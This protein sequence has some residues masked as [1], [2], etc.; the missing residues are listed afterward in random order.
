MIIQT[1]IEIYNTELDD[2]GIESTM[3]VRF[4]VDTNEICAVREHIEKGETEPRLSKCVIYLKSGESFIVYL[5]YDYLVS[6]LQFNS[7]K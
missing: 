3:S 4:S 7:N 1:T 5:N 6:Q 2:M